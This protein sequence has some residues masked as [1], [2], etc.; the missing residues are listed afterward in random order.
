MIDGDDDMLESSELR[1]RNKGVDWTVSF[2]IVVRFGVKRRCA[3][4]M[5]LVVIVDGNRQH[6]AAG[7]AFVFL[8]GGDGMS[9]S[10]S[11]S[12]EWLAPNIIHYRK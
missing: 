7:E 4:D 9:I 6:V 12:N 1:L 10:S 8:R 5:V 11:S 2:V 3:D